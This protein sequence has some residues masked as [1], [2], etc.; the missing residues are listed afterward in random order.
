MKFKMIAQGVVFSCFLLVVGNCVLAQSKI[1]SPVDT[2]SMEECITIALKNKSDVGIARDQMHSAEIL[3]QS[4]RGNL[5]PSVSISASGSHNEQGVG[6]RFFSGVEFTAPATERNYYRTGLSL[7][8]PLFTGGQLYHGLKLADYNYTQSEVDY[9]GV[10]ERITQ[11]V[12]SAYLDVLRARQLVEVYEKTLESSEAQVELVEER[13]NLGAVAKSDLYKAQT[14]AGNDRINLLQQKHVLDMRRRTLNVTMGRNPVTSIHLPEFDYTAPV[15]PARDGAKNRATK[16]NKDLRSLELGVQKAKANLAV[17][18]AN[19]LPSVSAFFSYD[20]TGFRMKEI[21][22]P[23]DKNWSYAYGL[24]LSIPV[25]QNLNHRTAV[26][27]R[28][29]ELS[30]N[31]RRLQDARLQVEMHV[32]NLIQQL[33]TYQEVIELN[34]LNLQSAEEDLRLAR[35]R[36]N[37]GEATILDVLDAQAAVT[38]AR[39]ILVYAKFDARNTEVRLQRVLGTLLESGKPQL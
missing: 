36:Y 15:I 25:F 23:L 32:E 8:Q 19:L 9:Q 38:N 4:A 22:S 28:E 24:S 14:R 2:L 17:A 39:R 21:Y 3:K 1:S 29:A 5:F 37:L 18:R 26:R 34:Q 20:R 33:E 11:E 10:R 7:N 30:I 13:Y 31:Q 16:L 12:A 6:K 27:Q 35:E